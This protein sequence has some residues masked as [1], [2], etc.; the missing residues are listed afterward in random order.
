[1]AFL[2]LLLLSSFCFIIFS[3]I[4]FLDAFALVQFTE[5]VV[6]KLTKQV[7]GAKRFIRRMVACG[8]PQARARRPR[9][10]PVRREASPIPSETSS[11]TPLSPLIDHRA[12]LPS[13]HVILGDPQGQGHIWRHGGS[14]PYVQESD[15]FSF[16][17][18]FFRDLGLPYQS[19]PV[20]PGEP[21]SGDEDD[22]EPE[23]FRA[24]DEAGPS[25]KRDRGQTSGA[26]DSD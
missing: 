12:A 18:D 22:S 7:I 2:P 13:D 10:A 21:S 6:E 15:A 17:Y 5:V 4:S 9:P 19:V 14:S 11:E 8:A 23:T 24:P 3:I 16:G 1:M 25:R 20:G 26:G